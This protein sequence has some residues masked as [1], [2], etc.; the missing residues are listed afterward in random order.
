MSMAKRNSIPGNLQVYRL[1]FKAVRTL[2]LIQLLMLIGA[3][4]AAVGLLADRLLCLDL[5]WQRIARGLAWVMGALVLGW[6]VLLPVSLRRAA[7]MVDKAAG[8]KNLISSG[9]DV[10]CQKDE[11]SDVVRRRADEALARQSPLR[12]LPPRLT[13]SGR[14]LPIALACLAGVWFVP[15]MDLLGR[16]DRVEQAR[17]DQ[18]GVQD[19]FLKL[20]ARLSSIDEKTILSQDIQSNAP[21]R[22]FTALATN[23]MGLSKQEALLKL[24]E[25]ESKYKEEFA[26][27]REFEQAGKALK[28]ELNIGDLPPDVRRPL[29][30][31]V[32]GL[33]QGDMKK[34][35]QALRDMSSQM[36]SGKLSPEDKKAL[37]RELSKTIEKM[38][39][40]GAKL[41]DALSKML[42]DIES[43]PEDL[44]A[45]LKK[46]DM[47]G[48]DLEELADFCD[49]CE[50]MS[51][52]KEGLKEA[53]K[54][55]LGDSFKEFDPKAVEAMMEQEAA[56]GALGMCEGEGQ[57]GGSGNGNGNGTGGQGRGRGGNPLEN[58]SDTAFVNRMSPGQIQQGKILHQLFISGVPDKGEALT[59]YSDAVKAARQEAASSLARDRIP[60]EYEGMIKTY[61]DSLEPG[62]AAPKEAGKSDANQIKP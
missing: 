7:R 30:D 36:K 40:K 35:A 60:R 16:R 2:D 39:E 52:M 56:M 28:L 43:S 11:A 54:S 8:L 34:A 48:K 19:A 26:G 10:L 45:L 31:F 24:G 20:T 22:E 13:L 53:K 59:E 15:P 55:M 4:M 41:G 17:R 58:A 23:L 1:W 57:L 42:K 6:F 29:E 49:N 37:A 27:Q 5:D 21:L 14:F 47:A 33:N 9:L 62:G 32:K 50:G 38:R 46:C 61:F 44:E 25:F 18:A 51:A 12:A 3:A